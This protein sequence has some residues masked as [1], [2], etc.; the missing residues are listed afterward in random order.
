MARAVV[1][2][3]DVSRILRL[4]SAGAR[5]RMDSLSLDLAAAHRSGRA[6]VTLCVYTSYSS[7]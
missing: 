6:N 3:L 4:V 2:V 7:V 1:R 5:T